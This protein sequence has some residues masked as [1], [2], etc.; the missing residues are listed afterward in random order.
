MSS[1]L[2]LTASALS[3]AYRRRLEQTI[4]ANARFMTLA[5]LRQRPLM[6][7]PWHFRS[8]RIGSLYIALETKAERP[9]LPMLLVLSLFAGVGSVNLLEPGAEPRKVSLPERLW[10]L[11]SLLAACV[12]GQ[13]ALL[14]SRWDLALLCR[15]RRL[16]AGVI[17]TD[18]ILFMMPGPMTGPRAGGAVAHVTG[19]VNALVRAGKAVDFVSCADLDLN[20]SG[21]TVHEAQ[22]LKTLALPSEVNLYRHNRC[23]VKQTLSRFN[24]GRAE[25]VYSRMTLGNYAGVVISRALGLPLVLEYN[26]SE[27][28]ISRTWGNPLRYERL[29][30]AAEEACLRH[31][32]LV[33]TVSEAL[34]EQLINRGIPEDRIACHPNG[35][36][37]EIFDPNRFS[38][39]ETSAEKESL[40]ISPDSLV[41]AFVGTFGRWH[42]AD[43]LAQA[44]RNLTD[45]GEEWLKHHRIR[46]VFVGDGAM[47]SKAEEILDTPACREI[48]HFTGLVAQEKAPL[49]MAMADVLISPHVPN[50]DGSR[51][52]GSPTKLF[53]YMAM[54]RPIIASDLEQIGQVLEGNPR[55]SDLI[56]GK[57]SSDL[58]DCA[59]LT[60]PGNANDLALAI[61]WVVEN[62]KWRHTAGT[63]ARQLALT[64]FTWDRH[65]AGILKALT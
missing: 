48:V 25:F 4:A 8:L 28:W 13:G 60:E 16:P 36:D 64:R 23:F 18:P 51:F 2:F 62:E 29:A 31:A 1:D 45:T 22:S 61:R 9:Y 3:G 39:A 27:V 10:A 37:P 44:I 12:S 7:L 63:Q 15:L 30:A 34:R 38:Q 17:P 59:V 41:V 49:Y 33:V 32:H 56:V 54:A 43:V 47:R 52:F 55:I 6:A 65:V 57:V 58:K 11:L 40:G 35:V 50:A 5:E 26:G 46:F 14:L 20:G 21:I 53:E 42:G 24:R 19:V